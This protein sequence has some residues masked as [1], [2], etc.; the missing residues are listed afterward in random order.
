[1]EAAREGTQKG[2]YYLIHHLV[3]IYLFLLQDMEL[4]LT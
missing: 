4:V 3:S 2:I 1:M